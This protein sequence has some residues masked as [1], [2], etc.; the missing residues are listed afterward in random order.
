M[1]RKVKNLNDGWE[2]IGSRQKREDVTLPHSWN[3]QGKGEYRRRIVISEEEKNDQIFIEF[4]AANTITKIYVN[5]TYAGKHEGGYAAFRFDITAFVHVGENQILVTVDNRSTDYIA[6]INNEGDFTKFG[7]IYRDVKLIITNKIHIELMDFGSSGVY[8]NTQNVSEIY[9]DVDF[10][11]KL[12]N[13]YETEKNI[14]V[15]VKIINGNGKECANCIENVVINGASQ[16]EMV[17]H[18]YIDNPILWNGRTN[19][20]VYFAEI[21]VL[22]DGRVVDQYTQSFGIRTFSIDR[23]KG[24]FLNGKYLDLHGVNHHQDSYENGWAMTDDQRE[25]DYN[26][27]ADLG[28][29][30]VRMAHY[31]HAPQEYDLCDRHGICVW[32]EI[33]IINKMTD[34]EKPIAKGFA[35]NVRQQLTELIRQNYNHPSVIVWG[36]SNELNQ[37]S[38]EIFDLYRE[39]NML[40]NAEDHTRLKTFADAQFWGRFLELPADVVGYNRYFGWYHEAGPVEHFGEW[41]DLYHTQKEHRPIC[42]SEYGGGG[43][44]SQ[45]KDNID[46]QTEI[47][48]WGLRHYENYQSELHEKIWE[49]FVG[50]QYLWG[51]F[52]W[53]MFDFSSDGRKE[54]DTVGQNDKG[55]ATRERVPKDAFYFYKSVWNSLPMVHLTEK[56]FIERPYK[57]PRVK[58]YSNA[59]SVELFVNGVLVGAMKK[60]SDTVFVRENVVINCDVENEILVKAAFQTGTVLEDRAVWIGKKEFSEITKK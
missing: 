54:G 18:T 56:R 15:T 48:P 47:D 16:K 46:W 9:S 31:Q 37:M 4:G 19:P 39:L 24:F 58:V 57:I 14:I 25:R 33:G 6:P 11:I 17:M 38:D 7:G 2:F 12:R 42:I 44:I 1:E 28:C 55:L 27:I 49:Q 22:E 43:A 35:E 40:A 10:L 3:Y 34:G 36:I 21:A 45:H 29:T 59:F 20:H 5:G 23:E 52:V 60:C 8:I 41:L 13:E 50:R 26:M 32:S 53:C 51:K 30:A